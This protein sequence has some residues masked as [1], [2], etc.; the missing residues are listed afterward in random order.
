GCA[1]STHILGLPLLRLSAP[2]LHA[3]SLPYTV[4]AAWAPAIP[5]TVLAFRIQDLDGAQMDWEVWGCYACVQALARRGGRRRE[6][7]GM[8]RGAMEAPARRSGAEPRRR[9]SRSE[10][11]VG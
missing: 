2:Y 10:E 9:G 7:Y 8:G 6:R 3:R 1:A 5:R 4:S 11:G